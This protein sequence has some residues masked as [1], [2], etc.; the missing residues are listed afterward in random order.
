MRAEA[1]PPTGYGPTIRF[2]SFAAQPRGVKQKRSPT[3][4]L[5]RAPTILKAGAAD[6]PFKLC[7]I[8]ERPLRPALR[9]KGREVYYRLVLQAPLPLAQ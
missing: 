2:F 6:G 1:P 4:E 9:V 5:Q 3:M 7:P 8:L